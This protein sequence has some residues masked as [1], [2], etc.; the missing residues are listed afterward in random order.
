M[1]NLFYNGCSLFSELISTPGSMSGIY[2]IGSSSNDSA[3]SYQTTSAVPDNKAVI[4]VFTTQNNVYYVRDRG[5]LDKSLAVSPDIADDFNYVGNDK[6]N[7]N[8]P[9]QNKSQKQGGS[10]KGGTDNMLRGDVLG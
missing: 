8:K 9:T 4:E 1:N 3:S 2:A 5:N 10:T 6:L 7:P